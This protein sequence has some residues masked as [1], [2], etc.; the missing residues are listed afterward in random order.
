MNNE[1]L[2]LQT[3]KL[4]PEVTQEQVYIIK[5]STIIK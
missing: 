3:H 5:R 4:V 2:H 1:I